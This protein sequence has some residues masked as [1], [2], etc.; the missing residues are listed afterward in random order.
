MSVTVPYQQ[1]ESRQF[2]Q[3]QQSLKT[4]LQPI[5]SNPQSL[6]V[7]LKQVSLVA[8]SNTI[9]HTLN[10][11]LQGWY[12][13]RIRSSATIYDTQ[14]TNPAPS[15]TLILVASANAVVDIVVY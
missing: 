2:N 13:V 9:P 5:T 11:N 8:G 15:Q 14:D 1:T 4:A 6:S 7:T 10:R 3:F 12:I